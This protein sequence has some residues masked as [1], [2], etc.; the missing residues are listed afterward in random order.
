MGWKPWK[1]AQKIWAS[2]SIPKVRSRVL[3]GQDYNAPSAPKCL[4]WNVFLTDELSY[5]DVW[6]QPF[7]LTVAY[8]W[9]L[10]Y[11]AEKLN[12]PEHPDYCPLAWSVIELRERVKE[13]V[14]FTK[15]Y[16]IQGLGRVNLGATSQWPQTSSTSFRR[17]DLPLPPRPTP[18]GNQPFEQNTSFMEATTQTASPAM[19]GIELTGPITPPDRMEEENWYVLVITTLIRQLNLETAGVDLRELVTALPGRGVFWNPHRTAVF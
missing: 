13:H 10:Q 6:Q 3:L 2:F 17:M 4:T 1:L 9:G 18:V 16:I 11:W 19:S 7:L 8:A 12:L 14:V 15:W 5:Q